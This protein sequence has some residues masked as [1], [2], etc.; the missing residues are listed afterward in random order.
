MWGLVERTDPSV[1]EVLGKL[2]GMVVS[3]EM[4]SRQMREDVAT[5]RLEMEG[6]QAER[7]MRL[8]HEQIRRTGSRVDVDGVMAW[9][10][11]VEQIILAVQRRETAERALDQAYEA[12]R[13][14]TACAIAGGSFKIG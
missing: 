12:L 10:R 3:S 8:K 4:V 1:L 5:L 9:A 7:D 14:V 6:L 2:N 13:A 11:E